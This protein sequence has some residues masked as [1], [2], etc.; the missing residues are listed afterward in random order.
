MEPEL[1]VGVVALAAKLFA[2][3]AAQCCPSASLQS[4]SSEEVVA[5]LLHTTV[6]ESLDTLEAIGAHQ[7]D[8]RSRG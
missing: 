4:L 7:G 3:L 8:G 5:Q 1:L 2:G 6:L